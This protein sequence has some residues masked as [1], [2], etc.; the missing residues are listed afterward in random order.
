MVERRSG[1]ERTWK[2]ED[3]VERG[4]CYTITDRATFSA[5]RIINPLHGAV[6]DVTLLKPSVRGCLEPVHT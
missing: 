5:R 1:R 3:V 4:S 2:R 6:F